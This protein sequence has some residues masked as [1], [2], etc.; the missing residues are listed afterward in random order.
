MSDIENAIARAADGIVNHAAER[1]AEAT[2]WAAAYN[3]A[4]ASAA[5]RTTMG[6]SQPSEAADDAV[7]SW[8]GMRTRIGAGTA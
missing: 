7:R 8:R 1:M 4:V 5:G 3:A 2:V 6:M